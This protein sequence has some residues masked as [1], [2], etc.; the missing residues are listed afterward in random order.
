MQKNRTYSDLS[1]RPNELNIPKT[2]IRKKID[3]FKQIISNIEKVKEQVKL[4]IKEPKKKI[5]DIPSEIL[6]FLQNMLK[7]KKKIMR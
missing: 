6:S 5:K 3:A 7:S 4:K 2:E 1:L